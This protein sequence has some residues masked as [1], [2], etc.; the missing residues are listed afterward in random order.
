MREY[1]W[2]MVAARLLEV[3]QDAVDARRTRRPAARRAA[4]APARGP[5]VV[6]M[7]SPDAMRR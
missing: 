7:R 5:S 3:Y 1:T 4:Y 6:G 2:T